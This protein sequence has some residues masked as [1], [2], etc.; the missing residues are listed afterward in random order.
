MHGCAAWLCGVMVWFVLLVYKGGQTQ[1]QSY[2]GSRRGGGGQSGD[3][4]S[5]EAGR[6]IVTRCDHLGHTYIRIRIR[7]YVALV[8]TL[9]VSQYVHGMSGRQAS[10]GSR[11]NGIADGWIYLWTIRLE[12]KH[13]HTTSVGFARLKELL[14]LEI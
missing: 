9:C 1:E 11:S 8:C 6:S 13:T 4:R 10:T 7:K 5:R 3:R 14:F 2:V 12:A